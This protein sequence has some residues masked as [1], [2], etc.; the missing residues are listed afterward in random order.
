MMKWNWGTKIALSFV[1]FGAFILYMVF[2]AFQEDF[3]LVS[4]TYYQDELVY[5]ERIQEKANLLKSGAEIAISDTGSSI[6]FEF[7]DSFTGA[8]GKI[9]FYHP[10]RKIFDKTFPIT[11]GEENKQTID[12]SNLVKGRYKVRV[13]WEVGDQAYYQEKELYLQ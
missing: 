13:N 11:L 2:Q 10:S 12:R 3:D 9:Y 8:E 7:P 1:L 6:L 5:Q 4:E